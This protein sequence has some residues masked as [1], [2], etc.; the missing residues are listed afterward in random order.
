MNLDE[1]LSTLESSIVIR[2]THRMTLGELETY[3]D[4]AADILR[5]KLLL[6][7]RELVGYVMAHEVCHLLEANHSDRFWTH[8]RQFEPGADALHGKMRDA[9]KLV[10]AWA[11]RGS[12]LLL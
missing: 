11:Q 2:P 8:L 4:K 7:S 12:G 1:L 10:P 9:W 6:L 3:L 5:G